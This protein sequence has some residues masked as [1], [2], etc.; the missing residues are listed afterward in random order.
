MSWH[1]EVITLTL[2]RFEPGK[3]YANRNKF[4]SVAT[5]QILGGK[6]AFISGFL[7]D[8]SKGPI[9][10]R[11]WIELGRLLQRDY[12]VEKVEAERNGVEKDYDTGPAPLS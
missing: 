3:S 4:A 11:D 8:G 12:G 9:N 10:R 6:K 1:A 2:R 7:T 5:C